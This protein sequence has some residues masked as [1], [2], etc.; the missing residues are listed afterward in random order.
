MN[1]RIINKSEGKMYTHYPVPS[2]VEVRKEQ[3][4]TLGVDM[5]LYSRR[6]MFDSESGIKSISSEQRNASEQVATYVC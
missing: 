3:E 2:E 6:I 4:K 5:I 1:Q